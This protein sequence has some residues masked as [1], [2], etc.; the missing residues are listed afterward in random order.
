MSLIQQTP[1]PLMRVEQPDEVLRAG[2]E[3]HA[4][5]QDD[6]PA[7]VPHPRPACRRVPAEPRGEPVLT[8]PRRGSHRCLRRS[9]DC[10]RGSRRPAGYARRRRGARGPRRGGRRPGRLTD[11][12]KT[13][14]REFAWAVRHPDQWSIPVSGEVNFPWRGPV[15]DRGAPYAE[16][17]HR[18]PDASGRRGQWPEPARGDVRDAGPESDVFRG[19][20][21]SGPWAYRCCN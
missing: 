8:P 10:P 2:Q 1:E 11:L 7:P 14:A 16:A 21:E 17:G 18:A 9:A 3:E 12:L 4:C 13:L 6:G 19:L 20:E 5:P 15:N